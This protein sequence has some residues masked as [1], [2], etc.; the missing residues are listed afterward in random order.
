MR[1][2][3]LLEMI[4]DKKSLKLVRVFVKNIVEYAGFSA[5]DTG[6]IELALNEVCENIVRHGYEEN[7]G[8]VAVKAELND[9][10]IIITIIDR[11][12]EYDISK[13]K[14]MKVKKLYE[15]EIK[16][17]LGIRMINSICDK[18]SYKR[19]KGKNKTVLVKKRKN[20]PPAAVC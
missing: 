7:R 20:T 9:E 1:D 5:E 15:N 4:M 14:P 6:Y 17:K 13:Y 8:F 10:F 19:L 16:G 18:V 2:I 12:R 3:F 11:G